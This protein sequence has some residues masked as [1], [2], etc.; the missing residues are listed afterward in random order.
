[1]K[2][3]L[4]ILLF[5]PL[6]SFGQKTTT[7]NNNTDVRVGT[8]SQAVWAKKKSEG[9]GTSYL[10]KRLYRIQQTAS[11]DIGSY[12]R[13]VKKAIKKIK[14]FAAGQGFSYK[15]INEEKVKVPVGFGVSRCV[16][17]FQ[18]IDKNGNIAIS[19]IDADK[20]RDNARQKLLELKQLKE[21]G[22]ITQEEYEKA[23]APLKKILL[24]L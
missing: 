18:L 3:L 15:I 14:S 13:Q 19:E 7:I 24:E 8:S 2:N 6:I 10:G 4:I 1:M 17:T 11:T 23:A 12:R 5:I 20:E 21:E 22:V 16:M 9:E